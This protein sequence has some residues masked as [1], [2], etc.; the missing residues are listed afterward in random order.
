MRI[1][2]VLTVALLSLGPSVHGQ[3][4]SPVPGPPA[5][6]PV[7]P[8]PAPPAQRPATDPAPPEPASPASQ[9]PPSTEAPRRPVVP[10]PVIPPVPTGARTFTAPT[11][12]ILN[13]VRPE[14]VVDFEMV[15][16]YLQAALEKSTDERVRA[17]AKGWRVFKVTEPGPNAT[18]LYAFLID[19][20]VTAADYGLGRILSDAYPDQ[21]QEIWK[22]YTGSLAGGGSLLN[23]T[24]VKPPPLPPP[25]T[26]PGL[27]TPAP[28][29]RPGPPA[30]GASPELVPPAPPARPAAPAQ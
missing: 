22:L 9:E 5:A 6:A 18:V 28:A 10:A 14:R 17:Q 4:P 15:I 26:R 2:R 20:A 3:T 21:I 19:P 13:A 11:G 12:I 29:A 1:A 25:G 23:L 7:Q 16:G 24:P 30:P 27:T 8:A